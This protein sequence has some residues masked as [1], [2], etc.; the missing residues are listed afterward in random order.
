MNHKIT[1]TAVMT[2]LVAFELTAAAFT[3]PTRQALAWGFFGNGIKL[4]Q[5]INQL[6]KCRS[7]SS[8]GRY[9]QQS[10]EMNSNQP[11]SQSSGNT[12]K[13]QTSTDSSSNHASVGKQ[14]AS[15]NEHGTNS[16]WASNNN[17]NSNNAGDDN[18]KPS[19]NNGGNNDNKKPSSSSVL[20]SN[21][22]TNLASIG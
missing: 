2:A 1:T 16:G 20:C 5:Q 18:N 21:K 19:D 3:V 8:E 22:G 17:K 7:L 4:D 9:D 13:N 14:T 6:N 12:D 15:S 10:Y 11:T